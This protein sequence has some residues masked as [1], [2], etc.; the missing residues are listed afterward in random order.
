MS[1]SIINA[2]RQNDQL[3][4]SLF[5]AAKELAHRADGFTGIVQISYSYLAWKCHQSRRTAFRHINKLIDLGI[6][7][8]QRFYQPNHKWGINKYTFKIAWERPAPRPER[9][10]TGD[11]MA[12]TLPTPRTNQEEKYGSLGEE[13]KAAEKVLGWLTPGSLLSKLMGGEA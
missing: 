12:A 6:I 8:C 3:R 13:K 7:G 9:M 2:L 11:R 5:Q 4:G 10:F 1:T